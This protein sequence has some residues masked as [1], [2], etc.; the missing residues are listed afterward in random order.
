MDAYERENTGKCGAKRQRPGTSLGSAAVKQEPQD[1]GAVMA[2]SSGL[3]KTASGTATVA[4]SKKAV[5][6]EVKMERPALKSAKSGRVRKPVSRFQDATIAGSCERRGLGADPLWVQCESCDKWRQAP[7][8][9]KA[10][11]ESGFI[12]ETNTWDRWNSCSVEEESFNLGKQEFVEAVIG[13]RKSA[14][15]VVE[16]HLK[17]FGANEETWEPVEN[18]GCCRA[19]VDAYELM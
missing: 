9:Q 16:Y 12:C 17:W 18:C 8:C 15:G 11:L 19:L 3:K 7:G 10:A 6:V 2:A 4:I 14:A 1:S 5:K 13:K